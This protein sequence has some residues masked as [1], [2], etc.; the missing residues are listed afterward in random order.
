MSDAQ[1][2]LDPIHRKVTF[3][4]EK[5]VVTPLPVGRIPA[6]ARIAG[7][8]FAALAAAVPSLLAEGDQGEAAEIDLDI[9]GLIDLVGKHGDQMFV[10]AGIAIDKPEDWIREGDLVEFLDLVKAV[11]GVN[12][13]FFT[14][15]LQPRLAGRARLSGGDGPTP[16]SSSSTAATAGPT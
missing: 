14:Q 7:P 3:R 6:M 13:D 10:A 4:Q 12:R 2:V 8:I 11:V 1:D 9:A 16:S 15:K 5:I